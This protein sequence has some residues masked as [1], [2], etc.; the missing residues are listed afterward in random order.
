[1][2]LELDI[3][4]RYF[5]YFRGKQYELIAIKENA[6]LLAANG[7]IP[8]IEPVKQGF[9]AL[10]RTFD[11]VNVANGTAVLIVNPI[12]GDHSTSSD[13]ISALLKDG[14]SSHLNLIVGILLTDSMSID[15]VRDILRIHSNRNIAFIHSGFSDGKGLAAFLSTSFPNSWH[16]F[17]EG[18]RERIYRRHFSSSFRCLVKDGFNK[19]S[20][21]EHP[22]TEFFSDLHLTYS[23]ETMAAFGDFLMVG[24]EFSESGGPAYSVAIHITFID[25]DKDDVMNIHHFK[26]DRFDTPSDPAGKFAEALLKLEA[27][28]NRSG[29]LVYQTS[30]IKE[31]L[32]L[33]KREH[34]PGLGYV[35][36]LS[37]QHHL[38]TF[39]QY[40]SHGG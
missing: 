7:F 18:K 29:T 11:A 25:S 9:N 14:L 16:I 27:E 28:V 2:D 4:F 10:I 21:R 36:K 3:K 20:N 6:D 5:P 17:I 33:K 30:A 22:P 8:I 38:E 31:F 1:M 13:E 15:D 39:A 26:S 37:M 24:D 34:F 35:K 12:Y 40:F 19:R 32:E 23:E